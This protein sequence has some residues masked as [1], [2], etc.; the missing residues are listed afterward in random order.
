MLSDIDKLGVQCERKVHSKSS[1]SF[2][3]FT[4]P[5]TLPIC[6]DEFSSQPH[7]SGFSYFIIHDIS[8]SLSRDCYIDVSDTSKCCY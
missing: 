6:E 5:L 1:S 8:S 3:G 4:G 2:T 7:S